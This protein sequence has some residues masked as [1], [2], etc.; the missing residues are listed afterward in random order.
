MYALKL[1]FAASRCVGLPLILRG[2]AGKR[3]LAPCGWAP[4]RCMGGFGKVT[5]DAAQLQQ[6][7]ELS[8]P[9]D[10]PIPDRRHLRM[11]A[12]RTVSVCKQIRVTH[13]AA[14]GLPNWPLATLDR[15]VLD[16]GVANPALAGKL[17]S[18]VHKSSVLT[19]QVI[20]TIQ[21]Q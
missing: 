8:A 11:P 14:R 7:S 3:S 4:L 20:I 2:A 13:A 6:V 15:D 17:A 10:I 12:A 21:R 1:F 19:P 18:P 5:R 16:K 9:E